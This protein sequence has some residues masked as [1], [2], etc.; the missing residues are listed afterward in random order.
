M[1]NFLVVLSKVIFNMLY[2]FFGLFPRKDMVLF[3]SRQT[4]TVPNDFIALGEMFRTKGFESV[5]LTKKL[6]KRTAIPYTIHV[7]R[8]IYYLARCKVCILE[9]YDPVISL[10]DFKYEIS[11][12]NAIHREFPIEPIVIQLWHAFGAFKRFGYQSVGTKEGHSQS[13][14]KRFQIH[15]NYSWVVA[16]GEDSR[17]PFAE[18]FG[19][20]LERVVS[21]GRPEYE[22]LCRERQKMDKRD[23]SRPTFLFSPTL[24]K[25]ASSTHPFRDL[26]E[27]SSTF[28]DDFDAEIVWSF[29]PLE[30]GESTVGTQH[31]L[32]ENIDYVVTDYSSIAYEAY[33]LGIGVLFYTPDIVE[34]QKSPGLNNSPLE[35]CPGITFLSWPDLADYMKKLISGEVVYP[36]EELKGFIGTTFDADPEGTTERI[37]DFAISHIVE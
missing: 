35:T 6:T 20:P 33:L 7:L 1:N 17:K 3:T 21:L 29:H 8:E 30:N 32:L 2:A 5:F 15:R 13:V 4:D 10:I 28:S 14:V 37:V 23:R 31:E 24:R 16:T 26:H 34:Y 9:R 12:S 36:E 22:S 11:Y 27:Q 25:S 18:A 19:Y